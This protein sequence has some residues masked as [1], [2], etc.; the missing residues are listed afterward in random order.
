M[1]CDDE[2]WEHEDP[3]QAFK[4]PAGKPC[5][6]TSFINFIKL[7]EILGFALRTLYTNKK[8]RLLSGFTGTEWEARMVAELDSSLNQWKDALPDF[9]EINS[10]KAFERRY[11]NHDFSYSAMGPEQS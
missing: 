5:S 2:Y 3:E 1:E 8:S 6:M 9:C 11:T 4:Q 7:C 10:L